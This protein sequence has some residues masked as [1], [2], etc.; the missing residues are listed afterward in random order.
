L[1]L[2]VDVADGE[3]QGD[4]HDELEQHEDGYEEAEYAHGCESEE[5]VLKFG[6]D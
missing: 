2:A 3:E 5:V 1:W 4:A 6:G